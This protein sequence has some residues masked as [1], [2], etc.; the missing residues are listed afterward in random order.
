[1]VFMRIGASCFPM[2]FF[3]AWLN[4]CSVHHARTQVQ[5]FSSFTMHT[6]LAEPL[7]TCLQGFSAFPT[8]YFPLCVSAPGWLDVLEALIPDLSRVPRGFPLHRHGAPNHT[9]HPR[10][11][12]NVMAHRHPLAA[13]LFFH[14]PTRLSNPRLT[15]TISLLSNHLIN[16]RRRVLLLRGQMLILL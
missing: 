13:F 5:Q 9:G 4:G 8:C 7:F 1:M 2:S 14:F 11:A 10:Q 15:P 3:Q 6:G 12:Q 16:L